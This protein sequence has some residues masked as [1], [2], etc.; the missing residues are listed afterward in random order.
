MDKALPSSATIYRKKTASSQMAD[1]LY[2]EKDRLGRGFVLTS[3]G[4]LVSAKS[5][6]GGLPPRSLAV[7]VKNKIYDATSAVY[8]T[9]TGVVFLKLKAEDLPV[10]SLGDSDAIKVGDTVFGGS[11]KNS[12]W[13]SHVSG[14][15]VYPEFMS[16]EDA[17]LSSEGF[18]KIIKSQD[19]L[20]AGLNGGAVANIS[21]EVVG[22]AVVDN[23]DNYIL[24]VNYFKDAAT[25]VLKN[26]K[27][28]RPYL[29]VGYIDLFSAVGEKLSRDKGAYIERVA[30]NSPANRSGLKIGDI[31]L[32]IE[33]EKVNEYK[34]LSELISEYKIGEEILFKIL[35]GEKEMELEIKLGSK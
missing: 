12:F 9:W 3:D 34:N 17:V 4:W 6:V 10:V 35:R 15:N 2:L 13:F 23:A 31:I 1:N 14:L 21:G 30:V 25:D 19:I 18:G 7:A 16:R 32:G 24:P 8:D 27:I 33:K 26:R 20:P 22:L 28:G 5:V 29:G 11:G